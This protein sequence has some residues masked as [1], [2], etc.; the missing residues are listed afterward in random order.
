MV[1]VP[2]DPEERSPGLVIWIT[3]LSG[4]GKTTLAREVVRALRRDGDAVLIDGDEVRRVIADEAI[5]YDLPSRRKQAMRTCRLTAMLAAQGITVVVATIS[6]FREVHHWNRENLERY[7][8]VFIQASPQWLRSHDTL[9][10]YRDPAGGGA[11][12]V[13]G[14]D[15]AYDLPSRPDV[16][17]DDSSAAGRPSDL[18]EEILRL[19]RNRWALATPGAE[20]MTP[21]PPPCP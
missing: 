17:L 15:L 20:A 21:D 5:G 8:E 7:F 6:L 10:L 13:V 14:V 12:D 9:G 19:A 1:S 18:A 3:G 11:R 4:A 16:V 2:R